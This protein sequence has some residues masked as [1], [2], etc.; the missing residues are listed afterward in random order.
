MLVLLAATLALNPHWVTE[1]LGHAGSTVQVGAREVNLAHFAVYVPAG[2]QTAGLAVLTA[3]AICG[4]LILAAR[5]HVSVTELKPA[6]AI[7]VI[8]GVVASPHALASDLLIVA[9]GLAMWGEAGWMDWLAL[10][11]AAVIAALAPAPAP[12]AVGVLLMLWLTLRISG[13]SRALESS[14]S[15][16]R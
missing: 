12:A 1:W 4:V 15:T 10:S 14:P 7:L 13:R 3:L 2:L 5:G 16:A 6:A 8:G 9:L 11:A